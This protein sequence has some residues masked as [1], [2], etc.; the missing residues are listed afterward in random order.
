MTLLEHGRSTLGDMTTSAQWAATARLVRRAGFGASGTVVDDVVRVG[1]SEWLKQALSADPA[2]DPG[3]AAS[4]APSLTVPD[5]LGKGATREARQARNQQITA[6]NGQLVTWWLQRMIA[7]HNPVIEK[8]TFGWH[9]HFATSAAKVRDGAAMLHQNETLRRLG[10]GSFTELA[11]AMVTDPAMLRWLDGT[12]NTVK[13]PNENLSR[14]FMELFALGHGG[15]YSE[16]DVREGAR[17]LT[18][19][20]VGRDGA[21]TLVAMRHDG[22]P[23]TVLGRTANLDAAGFVEVV[24]SQP[25][26]ASFLAT[27]WWQSL[28]SPAPPPAASLSR[29]VAAYGAGRDLT[30]LFTAILTDDHL[31]G[32]AGSI[33][34]SPIEWLVGTA[35]ALRTPTDAATVATLQPVLRALGQTP[36]Y[37][38]SVAGWPSGQAWLSTASAST[39]ME[40]ARRLVAT[41]DLH[42]V[43]GAPAA[44]RIDVVAHL[45]GI[46]HLSDRT[47]T[48]LRTVTQDPKQLVAT[49]LISPEYLVN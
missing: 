28:V 34:V 12:S 7:V 2:A 38:P 23:K 42:Q 4:P 21:A 48:A 45:L 10:R 17:A 16:Q 40:A 44:A 41:A 3:A 33:V 11:T 27:R 18:G 49:A 35:R 13:A 20:A 46:A 31:A 25:G 43:E 22:L 39:R 24:L 30:A 32:V 19:W 1:A 26:S 37:P 9:G 6:A 36:F 15:G 14:E 29:L 5:P 47:V 8:L